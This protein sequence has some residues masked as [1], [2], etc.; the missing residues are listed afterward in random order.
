MARRGCPSDV[1]ARLRS[2]DRSPRIVGS[3]TDSELQA[4]MD[5]RPLCDRKDSSV[6]RRVSLPVGRCQGLRRRGLRC[7]T[8]VS[9]RQCGQNR[10]GP[11]CL[12]TRHVRD[13]GAPSSSSRGAR[14]CSSARCSFST[15]SRSPRM[16]SHAQIIDITIR[17]PSDRARAPR[18]SGRSGAHVRQRH[19][20]TVHSRSIG[21]SEMQR[22]PTSWL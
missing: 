2:P 5:H 10:S 8:I 12:H 13:G 7:S 20:V 14:A 6:H 15:R 19:G 17:W 18:C 3:C 4:R 21:T 9:A 11:A 16:R 1:T 22:K